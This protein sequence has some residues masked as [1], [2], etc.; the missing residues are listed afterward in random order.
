MRE[1]AEQLGIKVNTA[2]KWRARALTALA[3]EIHRMEPEK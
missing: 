2:Y 3:D 1:V